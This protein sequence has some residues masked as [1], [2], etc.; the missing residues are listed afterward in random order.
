MSDALG[1]AL[2]LLGVNGATLLAFASDKRRAQ[3]GDRRIPERSLLML[4]L[5]G[6]TPGAL[7]ARQVF[8]HKTRKQPFGA[9]LYTIG[10]MQV[11]GLAW[12][13][14]GLGAGLR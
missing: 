14:M 13:A 1:V 9:M 3:R 11:A 7:V 8:R 12:L 10:A 5:L 6:G 4:A 2:W